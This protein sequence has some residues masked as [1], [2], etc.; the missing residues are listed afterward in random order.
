LGFPTDYLDDGYFNNHT[1]AV[2]TNPFYYDGPLLHELGHARYLVDA[3]GFNIESEGGQ[4]IDIREDGVDIDES[5]LFPSPF[6]TAK[7]NLCKTFLQKT[8]F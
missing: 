3:Y 5:G 1:D 7:G 8:V 2:T 4:T 6:Q